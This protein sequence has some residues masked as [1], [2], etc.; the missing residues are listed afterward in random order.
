MGYVYLIL[1]VD[2]NGNERHKIGFSKNHP[3]RRVKQLKTGNSNNINLLN[4]YETSNYQKLEKWLHGSFANQKT[5]AN[6]EWFTLTNEQV[7]GFI[8]S[9]KKADETIK[10]MMENNPFYK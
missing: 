1:E 10:F 7:S 4:F 9:C 6:N 8:N 5:E 3:E 2:K